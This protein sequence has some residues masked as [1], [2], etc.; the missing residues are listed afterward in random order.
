VQEVFTVLVQRLPEFDYDRHQSFRKWLHTVTLN[1]WRDLCRRR[2]V[3]AC[4]PGE[5]GLNGVVDPATLEG[6]D[7][8]EY[9]R[10]LVSR[11]LEVMQADFE[12]V[13]W[14]ACWAFVVEDR[15]AAEVARDL[16]LTI[17]AVYLAKRRVLRR[18]R[19][20]LE[21]LLD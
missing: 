6:L 19:A 15:S 2:S 9:R 8:A 12:P 21:G 3:R 1:K 10:H 14:K 17:N 11:A 5:A 18:L 7:E 4:E 16:G 20:E 13:T